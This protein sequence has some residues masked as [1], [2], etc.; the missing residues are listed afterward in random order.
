MP[1]QKP[2]SRKISLNLSNVKICGFSL[3]PFSFWNFCQGVHFTYQYCV[4][5]CAPWISAQPVM[6]LWIIKTWASLYY[7]HGVTAE[8]RRAHTRA[9]AFSTLQLCHKA[10]FGRIFSNEKILDYIYAFFS[11]FA[12]FCH[13]K[14]FHDFFQ[15]PL[16]FV[17]KKRRLETAGLIISFLYAL[18]VKFATC[19]QILKIFGFLQKNQ[20]SGRKKVFLQNVTI[21]SGNFA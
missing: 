11:K 8:A 3:K 14:S 17:E 16:N 20:N 13:F 2:N 6:Q 5:H 21:L 4:W 7:G 15:K 1:N 9:P 18:Y 10:D 12:T 19:S